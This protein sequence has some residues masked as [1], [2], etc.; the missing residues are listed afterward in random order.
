MEKRSVATQ[1]G[2]AG[3]SMAARMLA[4][5][6]AWLVTR[7]RSATQAAAVET[8][9]AP[10]STYNKS[11]FELYTFTTWL[12]QVGQDGAAAAPA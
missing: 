9:K 10:A 5:A 1:V 11:Q 3:A 4:A 7:H 12:L 2:S 8:A 6:P